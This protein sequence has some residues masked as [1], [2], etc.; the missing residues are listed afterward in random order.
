MN[1][2]NFNGYD[3][4]RRNQNNY[5]SGFMGGYD[6]NQPQQGSYQASN[7]YGQNQQG[8]QPYQPYGN[9]QNSG[10][11]PYQG[12]SGYSTP[13]V[14]TNTVAQGA[15]SLAEYSKKVFLWMGVGLTLTFLV[16]L[17]IA[18]F[19]TEGGILNY[20]RV[21]S[22]VPFFYG[23]IVVELILAI[24]LNVGVAKMSYKTSLIMF[25]VYSIVS[26]VTLAPL[27]VV[28]DAK[29]AVFAFA[30][31][32]ALFFGFAIYGIVT[33]RDLTNLGPILA[34]G[35]IVLLIYSVIMLL[36]GHY[37]SLLIGIIGLIIFIGLTAY[38]ANKIKTS[39]NGLASDETMLNKMSVNMAL[40]LYL[41]FINIFIYL[42]RIMGSR[43]N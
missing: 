3:P 34:I 14:Q 20:S 17:G 36:I 18:L 30:A 10:Y 11:Q 21:K 38:D 23:G 35:L 39:Y 43:R 31:A 13:N 16:A 25:N 15:I 32:A 6:P 26:G 2:G 5:D 4:N 42:L 28:Y 37:N 29:S 33:K 9:S 41:D 24:A 19:L 7:G 8:Y 27:L 12:G 1:N 40:Q 22:F